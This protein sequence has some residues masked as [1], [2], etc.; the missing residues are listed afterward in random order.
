MWC[1]LDFQVYAIISCL[2]KIAFCK[3]PLLHCNW[4]HQRTV[5]L[6]K[7]T[8][9]PCEVDSCL[10]KTQCLVCEIFLFLSHAF[11]CHASIGSTDY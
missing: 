9:H 8:I 2:R 1:E 3:T 6:G 11:L 7:E 10:L 4:K 5:G